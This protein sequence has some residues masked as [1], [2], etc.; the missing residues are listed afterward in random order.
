MIVRDS[1]RTLAP[2]LESVRPW[3]DQVVVVDTGSRD[4]TPQLAR[5]FGA[6]VHYFPWCDDF[7][8]ARNV[9]IEHAKGSWIFWMDSDDTIDAS[10]GRRLQAL[11]QQS[12]VDSVLGF[13]MQ[14]HCPGPIGHLHELTV[15]DHVKLFRRLPVLRFEGRIHEQIL[16][17]IRRQQGEVAWTDI[18]IVH[19]GSDQTPEGRAR[20]QQ[21]DMR[22]L[23]KDIAE[24]PDHPFVLFNLGMTLA[25]TGDHLAAVDT[26]LRCL[27]VSRSEESHLGKAYALLVGSLMQLD[28][29]DEARIACDDARSQFPDDPEL[30]FRT[31]MIS[32]HFG[33]HKGAEQYYVRLLHYQPIR[34]AFSSIDPSICNSKARHNLAV[35]YNDTKQLPLAELQWRQILAHDPGN[36]IAFQSLADILLKQGKLCAALLLADRVESAAPLSIASQLLR[37][38]IALA[39]GHRADA[40]SLCEAAYEAAPTDI[41]VLEQLSRLRFEAGDFALAEHTLR[42]LLEHEPIHA[43]AHH[44]LGIICYHSHRLQEAIDHFNESLRLRPS[45]EATKAFLQ[46]TLEAVVSP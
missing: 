15:V 31:A 25:D 3:V 43:A 32:H 39:R 19:S 36:L 24:R 45:S 20:K 33:D 34:K 27:R 40:L 23:L 9:S 28:R 18:F 38:R 14:V 8:A 44:N 41:D 16:P 12:H 22:I 21:R 11:A 10:N 2:C 13:V 17:A 42:Q 7:A 5:S 26:L 29:Y 30:L 1:T 37:S 46:A 35:L 6:E 4:A